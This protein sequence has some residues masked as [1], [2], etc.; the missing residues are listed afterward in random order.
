MGLSVMGIP[1]SFAI[2]LGIAVL[3]L[4]PV[5]GSGG[6]FLPWAAIA[7]VMGNFP[8]AIGTALLYVIFTAR[9]SRRAVFYGCRARN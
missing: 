8:T 7:L 1:Y 6:I 9:R 3:D 5:L 4:M 2:A